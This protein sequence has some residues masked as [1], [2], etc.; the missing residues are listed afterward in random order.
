[1]L[2]F[3]PVRSDNL[4]NPNISYVI[5]VYIAMNKYIGQDVIG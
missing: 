1:M 2:E 4:L 5:T 3:R